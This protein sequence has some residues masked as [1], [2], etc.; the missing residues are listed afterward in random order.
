MLNLSKRQLMIGASAIALVGCNGPNQVPAWVAAFEAVLTMATSILPQLQAVGLSGGDLDK[1]QKI[2]AGMQDALKAISSASTQGQGQAVLTQIEGYINAL[3]PIVATFAALVPGG[4]IVGLII[5]A[6]P[7]IELGVNFVISLLTP[8]AVAIAST[9]PAL[10][11][12]PQGKVGAVENSQA[13]L[14][15]LEQLAK[16]KKG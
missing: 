16:Q 13:Y 11:N 5:A 14:D 15:Y 10:P 9:A 6:L 3:A 7:A 2:V 1:A 12:A 4:S 8:Q